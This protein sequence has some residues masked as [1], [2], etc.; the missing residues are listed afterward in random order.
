MGKL[1]LVLSFVIILFAIY[2][3]YTTNKTEGFS[4][5][6]DKLQDRANPLAAATNPLKN[7]V[8]SIGI[9]E[10]QATSLRNM[11]T[12]ALNSGT[13]LPQ[14]D[15]TVKIAPPLNPNTPRLDTTNDYLG[16]V[17]FCKENGK[18]SNP[19]SN[20]AFAADC[21][22]CLTS[23]KL[24]TGETFTTPTGVL[25]YKADKD[26]FLNQQKNNGYSFPHPIPSLDAATC[27]G[28]TGAASDAPVLAITESDYKKFVNREICVKKHKLG[29]SCAVCL[30]NNKFT[31]VDMAG[32]FMERDIV[33]YGNG[34]LTVKIDGS[35]LA[36][37][38]PLSG[39]KGQ[40]VPLGNQLPEGAVL[41][42]VVE[43]DKPLSTPVLAGALR[44]KLPNNTPYI[45]DISRFIE[46]DL[47]TGST[48]RKRQPQKINE[49]NMMLAS[50]SSTFKIPATFDP[51][52]KLS[53]TLQGPLPL[54][55]VD[56]DQVA[57]YDCGTSPLA[58]LEDTADIMTTD[59]CLKKGQGPGNWSRECLQKTMLEGFENCNTS[60]GLYRDPENNIPASWKTMSLENIK[61]ELGKLRASKLNKDV[62]FT[63]LCTGEDVSTPCDAF[64][65]N[66]TAVP[67]QQCLVYL[68]ENRG[69]TNPRIGTSYAGAST[70]RASKEGN[71]MIFC[72]RKGKAHPNNDNGA[73]LQKAAVGYKGK[74]GI[75][76]VKEYL[77]DLYMKAT[78]LT[79]VNLSEKDGGRKESYEACIN[80]PIAPPKPQ[81]QAITTN[82]INNVV[83]KL[84]STCTLQIPSFTPGQGNAERGKFT[85]SE[86]YRL[87]F[88]LKAN[89]ILYN[90]WGN[91]FRFS[92]QPIAQ[93][94]RNDA[95]WGT[96]SPAIWFFPSS[97]KLH[98][99]IGD[100]R[101]PNWGVD[102]DGVV[103][104]QEI[105]VMLT[106]SG[107]TVTVV[108]GTKQYT[109]TQPSRRYSGPITLYGKDPIYLPAFA[110]LKDFCFTNL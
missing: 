79:D 88:K 52:K 30:N 80:L 51:E 93:A 20:P 99:R 36:G 98:I 3:W 107:K 86:N 100:A 17:K 9:S 58:M 106:C 14:A 101:D 63:Q 25:V 32:G 71:R 35:V 85:M 74:Q 19:F 62:K 33:F 21:G 44:S 87:S 78:A 4:E 64:L 96:R 81:T 18:G 27:Q 67:N 61:K 56:T 1:P 109:F 6:E 2:L 23:G 92:S 41:T 24:V 77:R 13:P 37:P 31:W 49:L 50:M 43:Q 65:A 26:R 104:K 102:I 47:T 97:L 95:V 28:A 73:A 54:T 10:S 48:P 8:A 105:Q 16:R 108:V 68:Y 42:L 84:V 5:F 57:T 89:A 82:V 39:T 22:M 103:L 12:V 72:T 7:P 53:M 46:K 55:F 76:G 38:L 60:G 91:L 59:P 70:Q 11:A 29:E 110:E 40:Q 75:E 90:S 83:D 94:K 15:G 34:N 66:P 69:Q 45:L